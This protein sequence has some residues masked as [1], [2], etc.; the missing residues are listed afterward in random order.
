MT[1]NDPE[2]LSYFWTAIILGALLF[3]GLC[4]VA[5]VLTIGSYLL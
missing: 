3:A 1:E 4:G 5:L 2:R